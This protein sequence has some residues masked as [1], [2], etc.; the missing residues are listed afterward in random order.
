M[1]DHVSLDVWYIDIRHAAR[2]LRRLDAVLDDDE[3]KRASSFIRPTDARRY[4][5]AHGALRAI[6]SEL[7]GVA[8]REIRFAQGAQGKPFLADGGPCFSLSHSGELALVAVSRARE[9]GV[10]VEK[11]RAIPDAPALA[12]RYAS[13]EV[14]RAITDESPCGRDVGFIRIWTAIEAIVKAE[15]T[16][17][18]DRPDGIEVRVTGGQRAQAWSAGAQPGLTWSVRWLAPAPGH[19]G[20]V[21]ARGPAFALRVKRFA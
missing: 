16:G 6:L 13:P 15:R 12:R 8:P 1:R 2:R 14:A 5:V 11:V 17:L 4:R 18:A 10:D 9:V 19:V 7:T 3:L 21:A 20:A